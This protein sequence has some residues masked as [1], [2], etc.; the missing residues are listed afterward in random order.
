MDRQMDPRRP[1]ASTL[2]SGNT[3]PESEGDNEQYFSDG[4]SQD[5]SGANGENPRKR[6][7]RPLS[8]S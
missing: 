2:S 6:A 4:D 7:R 8:V 5:G 3:Q 1:N